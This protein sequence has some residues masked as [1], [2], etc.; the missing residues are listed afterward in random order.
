MVE[1]LIIE[2]IKERE[3]FQIGDFNELF[4]VVIEGVGHGAILNILP[5]TVEGDPTEETF[6]S[7]NNLWLLEILSKNSPPGSFQFFID[8]IFPLI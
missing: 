5:L 8:I 6:E 7:S 2:L 3:R 4:G 1:P